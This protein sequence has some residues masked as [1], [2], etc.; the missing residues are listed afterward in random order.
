MACRRLHASGRHRVYGDKLGVVRGI[1]LRSGTGPWASGCRR[2]PSCR[3]RSSKLA[4]SGQRTCGIAT[5][6][7]INARPM[8]S[9]PPS[10]IK[11][12]PRKLADLGQIDTFR[13]EE[14]LVL[15]A[16][17][18][19]LG[20]HQWEVAAK[21]VAMRQDDR[22]FWLRQDPSRRS[23]WQLIDDAVRLGQRIEAA[24]HGSTLPIT[25]KRR[26]TA[27]CSRGRRS[28]RPTATLEQR[29]PA[30]LYPQLP[31]FETFRS[32]L[33]SLRRHW[34]KWA[35]HWA[36]DFNDLCQ[37]RGF[38]PP[39][40]LQQRTLFDDVV[41]PLVQEPGTT[42]LFLI[43]A[44]RFEMGEEL[45][46]ATSDSQATTARPTRGSPNCP[47]S[48]KWASTYCLPSPTP[49]DCGRRLPMARFSDFQRDDSESTTKRHASERCSIASAGKLARG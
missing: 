36:R 17:L 12:T 4:H 21:W 45:Y 14:E 26:L 41:R 42:A 6:S 11:A 33:D 37:Q 30:L 8:K 1:R 7:S 25:W 35:D 27:T 29:R 40:A 19:A 22:S 10:P 16:A 3:R 24:G 47:R 9:K 39:A 5:P 28:T 20:E 43:D 18:E 44:F 49:G 2:S 13:F 32:C 34:R 23:A 31:E 48:P 46:A 15:T 38:L